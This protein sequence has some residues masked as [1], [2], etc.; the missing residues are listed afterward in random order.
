MTDYSTDFSEYTTDQQPSDWVEHWHTGDA[1]ALV[2]EE[3]ACEGGKFLKVDHS[4]NARYAVSWDDIGDVADVEVLAKVRFVANGDG[5]VQ[6]LIRGSGTSS[7]ETAYFLILDQVSGAQLRKY[8]NALA[9]TLD[10]K[11]F[12]PISNTWYLLRLRA[13]GTAIKGKIWAE[14]DTEPTDWM[15]E[16]TDS[17]IATGWVGVGSY[18]DDADFD[19]I[20]VVTG[21][22]TVTN[23]DPVASTSYQTDFSEYTTDAQPSDW[24]E[25][26]HTGDATALVKEEVAAEGGK[27]LRIDHSRNGRYAIGWDDI[28]YLTDVE[29]L[30][31]V[32]CSENLDATNEIIIRGSGP[33]TS[34]ET[35]YCVILNKAAGDVKLMKY[36]G[37]ASSD[38]CA[39]FAKVLSED[40]WYTVRFRVIGDSVKFRIWESSDSEPG[41]WDKE[42]T[43]TTIGAGWAGLGSYYGSYD[44]CDYFVVATGGDTAAFSTG[45]TGKING[46]SSPAKINGI[47]VADIARVNGIIS[48]TVIY[49]RTAEDGNT[50]II[51]DSDTRITDNG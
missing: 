14:N 30:A 13:E 35:G 4:S 17:A 3:V 23:P 39:D 47:A 43:D 46:V 48:D 31:K 38:L 5:D 1:T 45:W 51:E 6:I 32:R 12:Y 2:K 44:D 33:S 21:G 49:T 50:R 22:G 24:V 15:F 37:G 29:V 36:Y 7:S 26:W 18:H 41:T 8:D 25:H 40:T 28:G 20:E 16:E 9:T 34:L 27:Y 19:W 10:E 11:R 42:E